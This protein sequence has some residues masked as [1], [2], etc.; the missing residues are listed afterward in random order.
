[1]SFKDKLKNFFFRLKIFLWFLITE[2]GD[3]IKE[4]T[5]LFYKIVLALNKALTWVYLSLILMIIFLFLG[6]KYAAS[7]FLILLLFLIFLWEWQRGYFMHKYRKKVIKKIKEK[8][9]KEGLTDP[10]EE[11]KWNK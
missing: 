1:M 4:I 5:L 6:N 3:Q 9:K 8:A 10:S 2:A 7:L 11:K